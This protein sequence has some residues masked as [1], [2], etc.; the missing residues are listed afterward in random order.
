M[1]NPNW[2]PA[3]LQKKMMRIKI[4]NWLNCVQNSRNHSAEIQK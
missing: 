1:E 2:S 3:D 4:E